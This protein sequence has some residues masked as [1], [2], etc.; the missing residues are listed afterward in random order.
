MFESVLASANK[1]HIKKGTDIAGIRYLAQSGFGS[2]LLV[3]EWRFH[4]WTGSHDDE[5]SG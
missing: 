3:K 4:G 1:C 2:P 5:W